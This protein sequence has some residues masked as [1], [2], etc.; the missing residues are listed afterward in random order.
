[1]FLEIFQNSQENTCARVSLLNKVA[2]SMPATVLKKR[3]WYRCSPVNF[4]KFLRTPFLTEHLR[5]FLLDWE[6]GIT[7]NFLNQLSSVANL[8]Q[9]KQYSK[10]TNVIDL[11]SETRW[12]ILQ[13]PIRLL[14]AAKPQPSNILQNS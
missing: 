10:L 4:T 1:M 3:L 8:K 14:S 9:H 12:L 7:M 5:W 11:F 6:K 2:G 13:N